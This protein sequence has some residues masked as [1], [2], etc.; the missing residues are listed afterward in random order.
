MLTMFALHFF[1]TADSDREA[2]TATQLRGDPA[3]PRSTGSCALG[4][5]SFVVVVLATGVLLDWA[6]VALQPWLVIILLVATASP[7]NW[8]RCAARAG[9][10][11][12]VA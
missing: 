5:I 9:C 6:G 11:P 2:M 1:M 10:N 3:P 4:S 8:Y 12:G 7:R